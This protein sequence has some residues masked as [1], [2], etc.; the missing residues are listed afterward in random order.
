MS[1]TI[2]VVNSKTA[3]ILVIDYNV[4]IR[5]GQK[6]KQMT[7]EEEKELTEHV[8]AIALP[9]HAVISRSSA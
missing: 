5:C 3:S 1:K 6:K 2:P 8:E 9:L 7:P 4:K